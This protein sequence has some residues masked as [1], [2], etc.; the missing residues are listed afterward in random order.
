MDASNPRPERERAPRSDRFRTMDV[1]HLAVRRA[2]IGDASVL[3]R[4]TQ[5]GFESYRSWARPGWRPPDQRLE[6]RGIRERLKRPDAWC[7]VALEPGGEPAGPVGFFA[8]PGRG[9]PY[10]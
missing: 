2:D 6:I 1:A 9:P 5:L 4:T 7:L 3:E 8:P 10:A